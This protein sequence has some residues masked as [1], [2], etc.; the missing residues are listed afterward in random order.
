MPGWRRVGRW[1]GHLPLA[2]AGASL[3]QAG[4]RLAQGGFVL[5]VNGGSHDAGVAL[6]HVEKGRARLV[7]NAEEERFSRRKHDWGAPDGSLRCALQTLD[8]LGAAPEDV[9]LRAC[10]WDFAA[11]AKTFSQHVV[12]GLPATRHLLGSAGFLDAR[13][14]AQLPRRVGDAL[15]SREPLVAVPHHDAHAWGALVVSPFHDAGEDVLVLVIDGMGDAGCT[16][17]YLAS[18]GREPRR[19]HVHTDVFDSLGLLY[20]WLSSTQGGW[21]PLASEGRFMGAAAWGD[22]RRESNPFYERLR[23]MVHLDEGGRVH[24]DRA[25]IRWDRDPRHP[26]GDPL[27]AVLGPPIPTTALWNPDAV[28]DPHR[29]DVPELTQARLDKAAAVQLLFEDAV[30]HVLDHWV[31][32]TGAR[33]V[34]WTGGTALNAV[35]ALRLRSSRPGL[36]WWTPPFPG[37][38]GVAAGAALALAWCSG[39]VSEVE[40][41][42]HAF[43]GGGALADADILD[44]LTEAGVAFREVPVEGL[45]ERVASLL[46]RGAI[47]G[48]AQGQAET[49]PRALGHRSILA[50]PTRSDAL[51]RLN[52]HV[53]RREAVR[54]LAPMLLADAVGT[55]FEPEPGLAHHGLHAWRFMVQCARAR[56]GIAE[57]LPAVVHVDGSSRIQVVDPHI[58]P[59][60]A[61][62][63]EGMRAR[64]GYPVCVNTS[65]NV[66]EPIAHD[67][68]DVLRTLGRARDLHGV[69]LV[70]EGARAWISWHP[71][72]AAG[73]LLADWLASACDAPGSASGR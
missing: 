50:D 73:R 55:L 47:L 61:S 41:L 25:W 15:G 14:A 11:F 26:Y 18:G 21:T 60:C 5:G 34:I 19:L 53:K 70:G 30:A 48:L 2:E 16:S 58:D 12:R 42:D 24:L 66:G 71:E 38:N 44:A 49:G 39:A 69:V 68:R 43:L 29:L 72:R 6:V 51:E 1:L 8:D 3:S 32:R 28:L 23:P 17:V 56:P 10:G 64:T 7:L 46:C 33:R 57:A 27:I 52:A 37:D 63:L 20:Q 9:W 13:V 54:P 45:G 36:S 67:A 35:A 65:L 62:I 40:R 31:S 22:G 59:L 4:E